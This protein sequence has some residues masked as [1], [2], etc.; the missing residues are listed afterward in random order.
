MIDLFQYF[1]TPKLGEKRRFGHSWNKNFK[2]L[3]LLNWKKKKDE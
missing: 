1:W 3:D 2:H